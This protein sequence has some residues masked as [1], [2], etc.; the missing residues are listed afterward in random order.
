MHP[1][2]IPFQRE[3][4][5][6]IFCLA[7]DHRPCGRLLCNH[8]RSMIAPGNQC[9]DMFEK[10]NRFE[11]F[12]LTVFICDPLAIF[13]AIIQIEHRCDSIHTQSVYMIMLNPHERTANQEV[14]HFIFAI[15][16]DLCSPV[17]MLSH[18]GIRIFIQT[19][20]VKIRQ[21]MRITGKVCRHPV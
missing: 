21:S 20:T 9:I 18:T 8:D 6:A 3:V 1:A 4:Q 13:L 14:L 2:H 7:G 19:G 11:I 10:L 15:I 17:R 5:P 16:K 12:I